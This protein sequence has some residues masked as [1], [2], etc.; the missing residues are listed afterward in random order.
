MLFISATGD[1]QQLLELDTL[2]DYVSSVRFLPGGGSGSNSNVLAVGTAGDAV[3]TLWDVERLRRQRTMT[4][5]TDRV[6][7]LAWNKVWLGFE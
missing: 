2:D 7:S 4:G 6:A 5:H 3:V 1:T